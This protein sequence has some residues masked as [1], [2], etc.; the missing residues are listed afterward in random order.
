[1][2]YDDNF[3]LSLPSE[4]SESIVTVVTTLLEKPA[5]ASEDILEARDLA[6]AIL[7]HHGLPINNQLKETTDANNLLILLQN[8]YSAHAQTLTTRKSA[9]RQEAFSTL[10]GRSFHYSLSEADSKRIQDLI[11]ELRTLISE[12][13]TFEHHKRR[14]LERLEHLQVELHQRISSLDRFYG[15]I[16][17]AGVLL[18]KFGNDAKPFVDRIREIVEIVWRSQA[19]AEQLPASARPALLTAEHDQ[20]PQE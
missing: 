20:T 9:T 11:N 17:D 19:N 2:L 13:E 7:A 10:I 18:G 1:M 8:T 6:I 4:P 16:G 5:R 3:V 12:S 15:L 14:I